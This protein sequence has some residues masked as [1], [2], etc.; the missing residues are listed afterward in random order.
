MSSR[1]LK[2]HLEQKLKAEQK[3]DK[4]KSD[5]ESEEEEIETSTAPAIN[6]FDLLGDDVSSSA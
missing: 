1:M 4:E 2:R 6:P 3:E 5:V